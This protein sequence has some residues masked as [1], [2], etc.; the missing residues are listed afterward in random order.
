MKIK[1]ANKVYDIQ[2]PQDE[3]V[4]KKESSVNIPEDSKER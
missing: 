1:L 2:T 3:I 4:S